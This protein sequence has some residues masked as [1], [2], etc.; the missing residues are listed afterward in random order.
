[1]DAEQQHITLN[2]GVRMPQLGLGVWKARDGAEVEQAVRTAIQTG[3]RLVDTAAVYQNE[4]GV[5]QAVRNS[6][7]ARDQLFV[8]TK[9]WNSD[10]GKKSVRPALQ[11]SLHRLG[12]EYVDLYLIHW[13]TP[14]RGLYLETWLEFEKLSQEGLAR[15]IGVCNFQIEHLE[16]LRDHASIVPA[17]NQIEL[18]PH[19]PQRELREYGQKHGIHIES[20]SPLG[21]SKSKD[22]LLG[23]D[24]ISQIANKHSRTPAQVVIRWHL[25]NGLIV[26]PKSVNPTRIAENFNVF[27]FALDDA[28]MNAIN[29][30]ETGER[31]G[32][33]PDTMNVALHPAMINLGPN[34]A[35]L[36][37]RGGK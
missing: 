33:N 24:T 34:I 23:S 19:L 22:T 18:N 10:Q 14:A 21:G 32:P 26:I 5:G 9:L 13:P 7:V 20:W 2:N 12:L 15:A 25:Q 29:S 31:T 28:D 35:N 27:D 16:T 4:A 3:Y 36:F 11:A 6:A 37:R 8:A 30:L 17:V 1:M